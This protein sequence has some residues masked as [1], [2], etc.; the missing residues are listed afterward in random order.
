MRQETPGMGSV[1]AVYPLPVQP[2]DPADGLGIADN[3]RSRPSCAPPTGEE[4]DGDLFVGFGLGLAGMQTA[5]EID[6]HGFIEETRTYVEMEDFL[7][8]ACG[9]AGFFE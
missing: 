7:P 5:R 9:I 4:M 1:E 8:F 6:S 3:G 2:K